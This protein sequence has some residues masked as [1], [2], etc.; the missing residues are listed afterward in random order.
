MIMQLAPKSR[1]NNTSSTDAA[2]FPL[3]STANPASFAAWTLRS[4]RL[5]KVN[6]GEFLSK[7]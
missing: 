2:N 6:R 1:D 5:S 7:L 4:K 3:S